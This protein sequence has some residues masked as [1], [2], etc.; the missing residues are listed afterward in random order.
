MKSCGHD[1]DAPI[2]NAP[3][4][5]DPNSSLA[6]SSSTATATMACLISGTQCVSGRPGAIEVRSAAAA[7]ARN[8]A[9]LSDAVILSRRR[10]LVGY[11]VRA[12][13]AS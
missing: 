8:M 13:S 12:A 9:G 10:T 2:D 5:L 7:T 1:V 6:S 3:T 4:S 11:G